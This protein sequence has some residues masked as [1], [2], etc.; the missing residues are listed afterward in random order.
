MPLAFGF[1][2]SDFFGAEAGDA[3]GAV[4]G[5]EVELGAGVVA[6]G[7]PGAAQTGYVR[8][9][10]GSPVANPTKSADGSMRDPTDNTLV[11]PADQF[12]ATRPGP[13]ALAPGTARSFQPNGIGFPGAPR[14][15]TRPGG[16]PQ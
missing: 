8:A 15:P 6:A 2:L 3:T 1:Q 16:F 11:I 7:A 9:D 4:V 14:L 10:N 12:G 5:V 13:G